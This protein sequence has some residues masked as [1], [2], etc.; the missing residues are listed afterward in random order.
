MEDGASS[1]TLEAAGDS[2]RGEG[3]GL[4]DRLGGNA[5]RATILKQCEEELDRTRK[6]NAVFVNTPG[7]LS[8]RDVLIS[9]AKDLGLE[10]H[11]IVKRLDFLQRLLTKLAIGLADNEMDVLV[12]EARALGLEETSGIQRILEYQRQRA[13][14]TRGPES[15]GRDDAGHDVYLTCEAE[16][17]NR[18]GTLKV[19]SDG[20]TFEGEV[21]LEISWSKVAH[22][23]KTSHTYQGIDWDAVAVQEGKRRTPT[24]FVFSG[25]SSEYNRDLLIS[26]WKRHKPQPD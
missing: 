8:A 11:P 23:A 2:K 10:E 15:L 13:L 20:L 7:E 21:K 14:E 17:R 9:R 6:A 16:Y 24:K 22:V 12:S 5:R 1:G 18:P 3:M 4:L 19:R 25:G 26:V